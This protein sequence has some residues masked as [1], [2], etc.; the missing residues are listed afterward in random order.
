MRFLFPSLTIGFL[1]MALPLLIHLINLMRQR[2]ISWGAMEFL[3]AAYRKQRR[4]IWLKQ[5]LLLL[6]RMLAIAAIV[7]MLAHL[8]STQQWARFLSGKVTHHMVLL[9]DSFSM[10][11]KGIESAFDRAQA[12]ISRLGESLLQENRPQRFTLLRFSRAAD[13][14][15]NLESLVPENVSS[16]VTE[17]ADLGGVLVD[18]DF[19]KRLAECQGKLRV[20]YLAVQ[21]EAALQAA[22]ALADNSP[23]DDAVVHLVSDFRAAEW[24]NP[25]DLLLNL[26]TLSKRKARIQLV[27]CAEEVHANLAITDLRPA[28]GNRSAGVPLMMEVSVANLGSQVAENVT[29]TPQQVSFPAPD[30]NALPG[31]IVPNRQVLPGLLLE[32]LEPGKSITLRFQ[33]FF[34][35]AGQ[36]VVTAELPVD[37]VA[38]DNSRRCVLDLPAGNPILVIDGDQAQLNQR[39]LSAVFQ[40][41][42]RVQTGVRP[43]VHPPAFLRDVSPEDLNSYFAIY[44]LD[45]PLLDERSLGNIE[46]YLRAGGGVVCF[47]GPNADLPFYRSWCASGAGIFPLVAERQESLGPTLQPT[48]DIQVEDIP[49]ARYLLGDQNPFLDKVRVR[50]YIRTTLPNAG[51]NEEASQTKVLA[52]LRSGKPWLVERVVGEGRL[53]VATTTLGPT[54]NSL[55]AQPTF[56]TFLLNL[57][58]HLA[59]RRTSEPSFIVGGE[60]V[61]SSDEN[62][63]AADAEA[64]VILVDLQDS[65]SQRG[66]E[67][68]SAGSVEV[69][70]TQTYNVPS[71]STADEVDGAAGN[72]RTFRLSDIR[73]T[74][75]VRLTDRPAVL[76]IWIRQRNGTPR[77]DRIP[78]NVLPSEGALR[79]AEPANLTEK[80]ATTGAQWISPSDITMSFASS[81][82]GQSGRSW[83][84]I[85]AG[86]LAIEQVLAYINSYHPATTREVTR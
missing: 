42:D 39:Y 85:I 79:L 24:T 28:P 81:E 1:L 76:E 52:R 45:V 19:S 11:D 71:N 64:S 13:A 5:F 82:G 2:R 69:R 84:L 49:L 3:L 27:R 40:P 14:T 58:S 80:L 67:S 54:W 38:A 30:E 75:G 73:E 17:I 43:E 32:R 44:L 63:I 70:R 34:A 46:R 6:T 20:S 56:V 10:S 29:L 21:P 74:G 26:Q 23:G 8:V 83:L 37:A 18:G 77:I 78:L 47:L 68:A 31:S 16:V 53:L 50:D 57:Q 65:S 7:A 51:S 61:T 4:W 86:L 41:S 72:K 15:A 35:V 36:Q 66:E 25:D 55:Y 62:T 60:V 9:D 22:L 33:T 59:S 12:Y 48:P